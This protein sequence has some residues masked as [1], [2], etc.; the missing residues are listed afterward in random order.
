[1]KKIMS[2]L[3]VIA[4][5]IVANAQDFN[6]NQFNPEV[7]RT[8]AI[9]F[10]MALIMLFIIIVIK[11]ILDYRIRYKI[12]SKEI[13]ENVAA[14][15]LQISPK[16]DKNSNIKWFAL[17]MGF[18]AGLTI[19][20]YTQPIGIH[21]VAIMAFCFAASFLGYFFFLRHIEKE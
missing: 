19:V 12:L 14:S 6:S 7:F 13:P 3:A 17:L 1:M 8:I 15:I 18:G 9:I 21:S 5:P 10:T 16:E 11:R 20:Y 4:A 2:L